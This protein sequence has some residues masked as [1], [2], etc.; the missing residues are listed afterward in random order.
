VGTGS[1]GGTTSL[2][3]R[4]AEWDMRAGP[5]VVRTEPELMWLSALLFLLLHR[6]AE[7]QMMGVNCC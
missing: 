2:G 6:R 1:R 4:E 7:D 5:P 3:G